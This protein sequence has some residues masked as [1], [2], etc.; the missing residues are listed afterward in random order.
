M[1][2]AP[3]EAA[4][5]RAMQGMKQG[6]PTEVVGGLT[7]G[8]KVLIAKAFGDAPSSTVVVDN[9]PGAQPAPAPQEPKP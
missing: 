7:D 3:C 5:R 4:R 1:G 8:A 9:T 6:R 2:C